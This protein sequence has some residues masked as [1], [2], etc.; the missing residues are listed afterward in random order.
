VL[1][2]LLALPKK[3]SG[4]RVPERARR[5]AAVRDYCS[6][7]PCVSG[8]PLYIPSITSAKSAVMT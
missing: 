5:P 3:P 7:M 8:E 2:V 1:L 6:E 4:R